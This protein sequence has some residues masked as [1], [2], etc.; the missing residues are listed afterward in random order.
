MAKS[1]TLTIRT[2]DADRMR[3]YAVASHYACTISTAVRLLVKLEFA[4]LEAE[5]KASRRGKHVAR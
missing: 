4:R 3:L 1:H 2:D 5:R